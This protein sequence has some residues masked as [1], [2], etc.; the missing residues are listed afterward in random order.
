[1]SKSFIQAI[2]VARQFR[3]ANRTVEALL[4]ASFVVRSGDRI[5]LVGPSGSGK[6]T[7]LH[8]M[9]GLDTTTGGKLAWP[10]LGTRSGLRPRRIGMVF[11]TPGLIAHDALPPDPGAAFI[12]AQQTANNFEARVAN[13]LVA[14]LD[15]ARSDALYAKVLFL[16]LGLPGVTLAILLTLAVAMSGTELRQREQALLRTRAHRWRRY[17]GWQA[18]KR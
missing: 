11:Q 10:E 6:S 8:L 14:R 9:A 5:A 2:D 18:P 3:Q 12:Q 4:P 7:L 17:C 15:G 16:F 13:N 1:M